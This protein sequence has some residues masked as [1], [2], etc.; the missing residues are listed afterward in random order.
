MIALL[1]VSLSAGCAFD[2]AGM[3][4]DESFG[5]E[6]SRAADALVDSMVVEDSAGDSFVADTFAADTFVS[7]TFVPPDTLVAD[8][9]VADACTEASCGTMPAG[10]KRVALIDRAFACPPGFKAT[11]VLEGTGGNGCTCSCG[12]TGGGTC[13]AT[14]AL[15]T[16]YGDSGSCPTPGA[17]LYPAGS[18]TCT[19]LGFSGALHTSFKATPPA[20]YGGSCAPTPTTDKSAVTRPRRLCEPLAGTCAGPICGSSF[21]ECIEYAG[22]CPSAFPN[23]RPVGT[24]AVVTCPACICSVST[25]CS[26][27]ISFF[28]GNGCGGSATKLTV[29]GTCVSSATD[30]VGSYQYVPDPAKSVCKPSFS[31]AAG[32]RTLIG[33]KNLCCR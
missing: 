21:T 20:P 33:Q 1:L 28:S 4:F 16:A 7:D 19:A 3:G 11:D 23:A 22:A 8:T 15:T 6:D 24:D 26:G 13:P 25:T 32:T 10:A 2:A 12:L 5:N 14:G 17:T 29:D 31:A 30:T 9:V 27:T 18:G